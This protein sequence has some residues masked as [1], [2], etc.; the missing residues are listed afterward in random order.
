VQREHESLLVEWGRAGMRLQRTAVAAELAELV[1]GFGCAALLVI[2]HWG[3]AGDGANVLLLAY[4]ALNLPALGSDLALAVR[5]YPAE[6]N[7]MLRA[8]EPL[9]APG[10][11]P[12]ANAGAR[13]G[14]THPL[15]GVQGNASEAG[16]RIA[17]ED[18]GLKA[19]G[20][21]ILEHVATGIPPGAHV[22]VV[23]ASGAGKSSFAGLLLGW[24]APSSGRVLVDCRPLDGVGLA[25]LR[26]ATVWVDPETR[27]WNRT[28]LDNL[29]YGDH[30][31][32]AT[33]IPLAVDVARLRPVLERLPDGLQ[34]RVGEGGALLSGGEG[35]RVRFGRA[36]TRSQVRLV[37]LDEPFRG[38]DR[39]HRRA[40]LAA[41]RR[42]WADATLL[43]I[44]HDVGE[45]LAFDRVLV[46]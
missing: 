25:A 40:L 34:T 46:F 39:E 14:T 43:C 33:A 15:A 10:E 7:V 36:L 29:L 22:A 44:T 9:G 35:Q 17:F 16:V 19:A 3:R 38:L 4:W 13:P 12:A 24:S 37:I 23:G 28:L 8:L 41:A 42:A 1:L 30:D 6:R 31:D 32:G 5:Q 45:T 26:R 11:Q 20:R 2:A 27:L 18:V 21:T